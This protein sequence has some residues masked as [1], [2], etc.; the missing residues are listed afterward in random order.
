M[1]V[2]C[3]IDDSTDCIQ[4]VS[5]IV[6]SE[7]YQGSY[8]GPIGGVTYSGGQIGYQ[9]GIATGAVNVSSVLAKKLMPPQQPRKP[10]IPWYFFFPGIPF[11]IG[12]IV[13]YMSGG[14]ANDF[15]PLSG[16][17]MFALFGFGPLIAGSVI[18]LSKILNYPEIKRKYDDDMGVWN[19]LYYC[20]KHG[21][22]FDSITNKVYE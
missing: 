9:G 2:I 3:P 22:I 1:S 13:F 10:W 8:A 17:L 12:A 21:K 11:T 20:H 14:G 18:Y 19:R 16:V 6:D 7:V 15:N 5:A 4:K